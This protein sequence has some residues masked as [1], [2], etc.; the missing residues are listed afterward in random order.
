MLSELQDMAVQGN[1]VRILIA[2]RSMSVRVWCRGKV[3]LGAMSQRD[4]PPKRFRS[5]PTDFTWTE[6]KNPLAGFGYREESG[7][8]S[9]RKFISRRHDQSAQILAH[10]K[11][12]GHL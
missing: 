5:K 9:R 10:L 6:L 1:T 3:E 2:S 8:G 4:K 7:S 11:Q 12:E